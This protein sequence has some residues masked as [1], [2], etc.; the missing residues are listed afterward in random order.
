MVALPDQG[1]VAYHS[2]LHGDRQSCGPPAIRRSGGGNGT[3]SGAIVITGIGRGFGCGAGRR[4]TWTRARSGFGLAGNTRRMSASAL[5]CHRR[6]LGV[7]GTITARLASG[8]SNRKWPDPHK[9][10][11]HPAARALRNSSSTRIRPQP[12]VVNAPLCTP[13]DESCT[14]VCPWTRNRAPMTSAGHGC[15]CAT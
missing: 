15:N 7:A 13:V 10:A 2:R 5:R 3:S 1:S 14:R 12:V 11:V 9:V 4:F 6:S 8:C